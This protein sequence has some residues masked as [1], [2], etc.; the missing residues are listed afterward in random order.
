[1]RVGV[2]GTGDVGKTLGSALTT[3]GH[4]VMMGARE[5]QNPKAL[6]WAASQGESVIALSRTSE[7]RQQEERGHSG[8]LVV[9]RCWVSGGGWV[10]I[11][12]CSSIRCASAAA[13]TPS[14][15]PLGSRR[16]GAHKRKVLDDRP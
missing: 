5:A 16:Q 1:M 15:L 13:G 12:S 6:E 14:C 8:S 10:N 3:L 9:I 7:Q 2:F 11:R 4:E